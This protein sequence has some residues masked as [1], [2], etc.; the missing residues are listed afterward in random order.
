MGHT[1]LRQGSGRDVGTHTDTH[2]APVPTVPAGASTS[3]GNE[4]VRA[5][6]GSAAREEPQRL[7]RCPPPEQSPQSRF[8]LS[9]D[10]LG[11]SRRAA[12]TVQC[13]RA[14]GEGPTGPSAPRSGT[15]RKAGGGGDAS[16]GG[17]EDPG[18]M[19]GTNPRMDKF[20]HRHPEP[21]APPTCPLVLSQP[22]QGWT[23][24]AV[25]W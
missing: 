11:Y 5:A 25:S 10:L 4:Q 6:L 16:G 21:P 8:S 2:G 12:R 13:E 1:G 23:G 22:G 3:G 7:P 15:G 9:R 18:V 17:E 19:E 20:I 24:K 14:P